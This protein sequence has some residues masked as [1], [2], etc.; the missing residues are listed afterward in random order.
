MKMCEGCRVVWYCCKDCQTISWNEGG[1]KKD[2]KILRERSKMDY[3]ESDFEAVAE[4]KVCKASQVNLFRCSRCRS[5]SYCSK[6]C[7]TL[8][9]KNG[10][11]KTCIP[12]KKKTSTTTSG[13]GSDENPNVAKGKKESTN[14]CNHV[15]G[16]AAAVEISIDTTTKKKKKKKT[17]ILVSATTEDGEE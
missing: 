4:C 10:H 5:V 14:N 11:K 1:H 12:V 6:A 13:S 17:S 3:D 15:T 9:W 8:H 2:C 16:A 7:Q